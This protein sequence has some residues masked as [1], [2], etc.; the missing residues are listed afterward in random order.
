CLKIG[1][2][3]QCRITV[4]LQG[5]QVIAEVERAGHVEL[6]YRSAI[7]E[8]LQKLDLCCAQ[9]DYRRFDLRLILNSQQ[10]DAVKINLG[11]VASFQTGATD[12]DNLVVVL[13]VRLC[14]VQHELGLER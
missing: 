5:L 7:V 4:T 2:C 3:F 8:H 9:V 13:E 1:P 6:V 12:V 10:F 11:D 14:Q